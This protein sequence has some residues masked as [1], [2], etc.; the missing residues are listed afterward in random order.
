[1][2]A[3]ILESSLLYTLYWISVYTT[4]LEIMNQDMIYIQK[5]K[6]QYTVNTVNTILHAALEVQLSHLACS[7]FN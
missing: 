7:S 3:A 1:M 6:I 2:V 4:H 5:Q